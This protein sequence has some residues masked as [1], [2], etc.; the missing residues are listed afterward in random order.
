MIKLK[1]L[2]TEI[3]DATSTFPIRN[4][5]EAIKQAHD[6][7]K[8]I[9][10]TPWQAIAS[11]NIIKPIHAEFLVD[12]QKYSLNYVF[13]ASVKLNV[14]DSP[15]NGS[16]LYIDC[17]IGFAAKDL[18]KY[19]ELAKTLTTTLY[20]KKPMIRITGEG[21]VSKDRKKITIHESDIKY[22]NSTFLVEEISK[23]YL[24]GR[25]ATNVD[26]IAFAAGY[27]DVD[28]ELD[29][30]MQA[31]RPLDLELVEACYKSTQYPSLIFVTRKTTPSAAVSIT[32]AY[33]DFA[34]QDAF[35]KKL[36]NNIVRHTSFDYK[37][38]VLTGG[39]KPLSVLST[40]TNFG[41]ELMDIIPTN[42]LRFAPAARPGEEEIDPSQSGRGK[43]YLA[44]VKK[45]FPTANVSVGSDGYI[46]VK[47]KHSVKSIK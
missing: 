16:D 7:V 15:E 22:L 36:I 26:E 43:L 33:I 20:D 34:K 24:K 13:D 29:S 28:F 31:A 46:Y 12:K 19:P 25:N 4:K 3:G 18:N 45:Q 23:T 30:A 1:A 27:D 8:Q 14:F 38:K 32:T 17:T 11:D 2:L 39:G 40:I 6:F 10:D 37:D 35:T 47:F 9:Q 42:E 41:K 21:E 44:F 5:S